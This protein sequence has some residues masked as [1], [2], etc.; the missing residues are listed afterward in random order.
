M[1]IFGQRHLRAILDEYEVH[2]TTDGAPIAA[3]SSDH[4]GPTTPSPTF[5][6]SGSSASPSSLASS[7]NTSGPHRSRGQDRWPSS[8]TPQD[9]SSPAAPMILL[10]GNRLKG[11]SGAAMRA[12]R[13]P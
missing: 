10:P 12:L 5:L 6:R 8:G 4:P 9:R 3:S 1:L 7:T 2:T 11:A 13:A